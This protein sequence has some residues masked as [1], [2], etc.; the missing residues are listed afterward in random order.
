VDGRRPVRAALDEGRGRLERAGLPDPLREAEI[1]LAAVL[2]VARA[3]L[4]V[5][6]PAPAPADLARY[7]ALLARRERREPAAYLLGRCEFLSRE[8][9][10]TPAVLV[11]RPETEHLVEAALAEIPRDGA[12]LAVDVGTGSGCIAVSVAAE[13]PGAR[14]VALDRSAAALAVAGENA[15]RHG[16]A[17]RVLLF[18]GDLLGAVRGPVDLVLSN[19]PYVGTGETVDPEVL[20]EPREAVFAGPDG[21]EAYRALAPAAARVLRPGGLL[22]VETPGARIEE[23]AAILRAAGL[24]P[25]PPLPDLAGR[26]RVLGGTRPTA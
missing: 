8:F 23:I 13:R 6:P 11:P 25:R 19:P 16:V 18:R 4:H 2:G 22:L 15:R 26:P 10:V 7:A 24:A 21:L 17:D 9:L 12:A 14:V 1:L 3:S 5:D 20:H